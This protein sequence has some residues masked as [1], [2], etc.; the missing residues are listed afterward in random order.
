MHFGVSAVLT[1]ALSLN[2]AASS[3]VVPVPSLEHQNL[4]VESAVP[5]Y[6]ALVLEHQKLSGHSDEEEEEEG[7]AWRHRSG[8]LVE[9]L[10]TPLPES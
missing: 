10:L 9:P 6:H 8:G 7:R 2:E 1:P 5:G 4:R 3:A